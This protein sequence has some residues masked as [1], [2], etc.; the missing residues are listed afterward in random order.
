MPHVDTPICTL[1]A[2]L[3]CAAYHRH[4][5]QRAAHTMPRA[6]HDAPSACMALSG[7]FAAA[8]PLLPAVS[9]PMLSAA[10][11]ATALCPC[12]IGP[13]TVRGGT[14]QFVITMLCR[15]AR[16]CTCV[17]C[18][19]DYHPSC[20]EE[21]LGRRDRVVQVK[22]LLGRLRRAGVSPCLRPISGLRLASVLPADTRCNFISPQSRSV[23]RRKLPG[24][25]TGWPCLGLRVGIRVRARVQVRVTVSVHAR[26]YS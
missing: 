25:G 21:H 4:D 10:A 26:L 16:W 2:T 3:Q 1:P 11:A 9:S 23:R 12:Y 24:S 6:G 7:T 22:S 5:A 14:V 8:C 18:R 19:H 20:T 15:R 17:R 13:R